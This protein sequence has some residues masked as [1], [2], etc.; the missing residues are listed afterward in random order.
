MPPTM[1]LTFG[2]LEASPL[3][4]PVDD[5]R[6]QAAVEAASTAAARVA[7]M[8]LVVLFMRILLVVVGESDGRGLAVGRRPPGSESSFEPGDQPLGNEGDHG[9]HEHPGVDAGRVE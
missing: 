8:R 4:D 6:P 9:D 3:S 1:M 5:V 7:A 2:V